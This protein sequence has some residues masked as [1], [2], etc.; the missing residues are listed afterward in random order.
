MLHHSN[1]KK[2]KAWNL[3]ARIPTHTSDHPP[4]EKKKKKKIQ[5]PIT[6]A[7]IVLIYYTTRART[8][9]VFRLAFF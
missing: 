8:R 1:I 5:Q 6:Y 4:T 7:T 2:I 3:R 9:M